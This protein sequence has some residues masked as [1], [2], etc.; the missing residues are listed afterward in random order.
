MRYEIIDD[1]VLLY[2]EELTT[3][4]ISQPSWPDGTPWA[5]GEAEAWAKQFIKFATDPEAEMPGD[6]P[7]SPTKPRPVAPTN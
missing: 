1:V 7:A 5:V 2:F 4:A 6:K 3:P